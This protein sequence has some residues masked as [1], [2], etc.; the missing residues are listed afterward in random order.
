MKIGQLAKR[1]R[2]PVE[3]IRYY[4]RE[5]LLPEPQRS[6]ANY[7]H[8]QQQ[9]LERLLFIR[10]C[11]A[12]DLSLAEIRTL[13]EV[14]DNPNAACDTA[15]QVLD[16]HIQHVETRIHELQAL[17][18]QLRQL[19]SKCHSEKAASDCGILQSISKSNATPMP[20]SSHI[21]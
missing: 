8:Y 4:E 14:K 6:A 16:E 10:Q 1:A 15:N 5:A 20:S 3:T 17:A 19:R 13:L 11:R 21:K 7:R 18:Q 2:T 9:H 12:L